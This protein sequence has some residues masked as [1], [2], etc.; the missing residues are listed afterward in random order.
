M[1]TDARAETAAFGF[2]V[3]LMTDLIMF[4]VLFATFL[5]LRTGTFGG[6]TPADLNLGGALAE[7]F[8][9][10]ASSVSCS[11]AMIE[12][13]RK[14]AERAIAW[15]GVTFAFGAGFLALE[16]S[17]FASLLAAGNG[18]GQSAFLS[19]FFT[20]VGTHGLHITIGLLWIAVS[21]VMLKVRGLT[22]HVVSILQRLDL[23]WHFLDL[24]WIFIFAVVYLLG[25][26][27]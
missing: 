1:S 5:V 12:V 13:R 4:A 6:P 27:M 7:T 26:A 15:F 2:W 8:V 23:F 22:E 14:R 19:A 9:L 3:Y 17:E 18:P 11:L 10:L 25:H 21:I 16:L 20:L 24:V